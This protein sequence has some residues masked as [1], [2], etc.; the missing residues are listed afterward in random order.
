MVRKEAVVVILARVMRLFVTRSR[1]GETGK[2]GGDSG[3]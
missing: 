3:G 1:T 2:S